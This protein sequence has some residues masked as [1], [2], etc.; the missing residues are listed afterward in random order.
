MDVW[1]PKILPHGVPL[2][3]WCLYKTKVFR[4]DWS[5][6][7]TWYISLCCHNGMA[8][9]RRW[10]KSYQFHFNIIF[11][12]HECIIFLLGWYTAVIVR[13]RWYETR[14]PWLL[15][16]QGHLSLNFIFHF[17]TACRVTLITVPSDI[18]LTT[19]TIVRS[20]SD[21]LYRLPALTIIFL[22]TSYI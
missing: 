4:T 13:C 12:I 15:M 20:Q 5:A 17:W 9:K 22:L 21:V 14:L 6:F 8:L 3:D 10:N 2:M 16:F 19:E 18:T 1:L 11:Y 7:K